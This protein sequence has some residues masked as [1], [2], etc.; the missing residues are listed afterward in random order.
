M[1]SVEAY[2]LCWPVGRPR[3]PYGKRS[4]AKFHEVTETYVRL[5]REFHPDRGGS[6]EVMAEINNAYEAFKIERGL[7]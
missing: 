1:P 5:C 2:P 3:T 7:A 6:E 4:R